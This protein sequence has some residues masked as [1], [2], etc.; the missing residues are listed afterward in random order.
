M[1]LRSISEP[2]VE[3]NKISNLMK[4]EKK[5]KETWLIKASGQKLQCATYIL[6]LYMWVTLFTHVAWAR[7][8]KYIYIKISHFKSSDH[9]TS[10]FS[11]LTFCLK[12]N[13][14]PMNCQKPHSFQGLVI[15]LSSVDERAAADLSITAAW[16]NCRA[17]S[18]ALLPPWLSFGF[19][20]RE[21]GMNLP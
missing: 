6:G 12:P 18:E 7:A 11:I 14:S 3:I 21:L 5:E 10:I 16:R 15:Y 4:S 20:E 2:E 19:P 17:I 9:N 8:F 1:V 13:L